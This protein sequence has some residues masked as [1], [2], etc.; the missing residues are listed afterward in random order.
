MAIP[1][2]PSSSA[3]DCSP[4]NVFIVS[5]NTSLRDELQEKLV[6]PRWNVIQASSGAVALEVL[7]K[8]GTEDGILLLDPN[9][10]DL[11]PI[12]FDGLVRDRFPN[13]QVLMLNG[14]TG[15]LLIGSASPTPE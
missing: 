6:L 7:R 3:G 5:P 2:I 4:I 12:E 11:E 1:A 9:L 10:P 13:T 15:R 8:Q 14:Q